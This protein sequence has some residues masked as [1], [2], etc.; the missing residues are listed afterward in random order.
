MNSLHLVRLNI[1]NFHFYNNEKELSYSEKSVLLHTL[2]IL[3][4]LG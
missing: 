4:S 3:N 2:L 1:Q